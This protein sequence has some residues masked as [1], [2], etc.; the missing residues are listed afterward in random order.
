MSK[1]LTI[2][3][4]PNSSYQSKIWILGSIN[5]YDDIIIQYNSAIKYYFKYN[6]V[7]TYS[8]F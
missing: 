5:S 2:K 8:S 3:S 1:T 7:L 4:K 6:H